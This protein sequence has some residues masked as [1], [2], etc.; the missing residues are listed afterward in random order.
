MVKLDEEKSKHGLAHENGFGS[1]YLQRLRWLVKGAAT[2][3]TCIK[4]C[5]KYDLTAAQ[6]FRLAHHIDWYRWF[7]TVM[8]HLFTVPV[9]VL[10]VGLRK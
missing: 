1:P 6:C 9:S 2:L 3:C 10:W 8:L 5:N 7:A 4:E